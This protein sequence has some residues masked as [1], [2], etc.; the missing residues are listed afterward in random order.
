MFAEERDSRPPTI[1]IAALS[2]T[3]LP[4]AAEWLLSSLRN[5]GGSWALGLAAVA[6]APCHSSLSPAKAI[7]RSAGQRVSTG[8]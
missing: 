8:A 3:I 4:W 6:T 2:H 5:C 7:S 1:L